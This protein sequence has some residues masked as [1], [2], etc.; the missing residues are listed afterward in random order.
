[1]EACNDAKQVNGIILVLSKYVVLTASGLYILYIHSFIH[2]IT[3][4]LDLS[5]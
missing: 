2:V 1:M 3:L 4:A 5:Q